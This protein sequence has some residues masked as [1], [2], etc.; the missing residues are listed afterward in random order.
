MAGFS[1]PRG[2][3]C[4]APDVTTFRPLNVLGVCVS[5]T[6]I[7]S[8]AIR[9]HLRQE[10]NLGLRIRGIEDNRAA[11][12]HSLHRNNVGIRRKWRSAAR[13]SS[14]PRI[15]SPRFGS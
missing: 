11:L 8:F 3:N 6:K 10:P 15:L 4:T 13:L 7:L 9:L 5:L 2:A 12:L 14:I 1:G